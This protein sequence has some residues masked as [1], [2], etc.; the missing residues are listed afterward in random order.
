[1]TSVR[2]QQLVYMCQLV[3]QQ[4][5]ES[6]FQLHG[7]MPNWF[8]LTH[9]L[10]P[11]AAARPHSIYAGTASG[12]QIRSYLLRSGSHHAGLRGP[13]D[14]LLASRHS[15]N[16]LIILFLDRDFEPHLNQTQHI[17]LYDSPSDT[18]HQFAVWDGVEGNHDTLPII[19]TFLNASSSRVR[20]THS[21]DN[22]WRSFGKPACQTACSSCSFYPTAVSR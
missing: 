11:A 5:I 6:I 1:M 18:L 12:A 10:G 8:R 21:K 9:A 17:P 19:G 20:I 4:T 3:R 13:A 7:T 2:D 16:P 14:V 15:P 22:L